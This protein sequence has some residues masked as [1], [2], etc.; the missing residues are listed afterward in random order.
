M[1]C[2]YKGYTSVVA[3][4][5]LGDI[6]LDIADSTKHAEENVGLRYG[7]AG[8]MYTAGVVGLYL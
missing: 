4:C 7:L 3:K 1:Q 8:Y 2:K 6:Q 5:C